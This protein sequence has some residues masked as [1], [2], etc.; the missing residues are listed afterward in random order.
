MPPIKAVRDAQA[1]AHAT[2]QG[3]DP[4]GPIVTGCVEAA[5]VFGQRQ[6]PDGATTRNGGPRMFQS[7]RGSPSG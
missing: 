5:L 4:N 2:L 7:W 3:E 1:R 6:G